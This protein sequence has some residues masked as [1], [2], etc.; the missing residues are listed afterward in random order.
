VGACTLCAV[1]ALGACSSDPESTDTATQGTESGSTSS[2]SESVE[3]SV[4]VDGGDAAP[5]AGCG[6]ALEDVPPERVLER[7]IDSAGGERSYL[8]YVPRS[9]DPERPS[10][11]AFTFHGAGSTKEQQFVYSGFAVH[12]EEDAALVVAPDALGEPRRWSPYGAERVSGPGGVE[13]VRDLDFFEDLLD[14]IEDGFCVDTTRIWSTGMSSGGFM[15][16]TIACEYSDR[17]AAAAPVTATAW[18]DTACGGAL[19]VPYAYF[20]GTEDRVVPFLG[21]VPGPD[22]EPGPGAAEVSTAQWASHN[23]CGEE[24]ADERVGDEVIHRTW[25]DC[26][27]PTDL[28]IIE[29]GGHTWPGAAPVEHLGHTTDDISATEIIWELFRTS[30]RRR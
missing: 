27:A 12:A 2:P 4:S 7:T 6:T 24:P 20:H 21:P 3:P 22:G 9:Y 5:S 10:P 30:A 15:T 18:S 17:L 19:P 25:A 13:G 29:G 14:E 1:I 26:D 8:V 28:Y 23:G 16:A 11:V